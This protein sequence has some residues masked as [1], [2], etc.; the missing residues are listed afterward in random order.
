MKMKMLVCV[1]VIQLQAEGLKNLE[2]CGNFRSELTTD[3]GKEKN[4]AP[5]TNHALSETTVSVHE[6]GYFPAG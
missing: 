3:M 2:L 6:I 4:P 5:V 1:D